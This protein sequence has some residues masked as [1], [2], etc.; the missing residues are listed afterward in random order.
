M[1]ISP[2]RLWLQSTSLLAV[3]AGYSL[4]LLFNQGMAG[5]QRRLAYERLVS[6]LVVE[7]RARAPNANQ[8][9]PLLRQALLPSLR[10]QLLSV[11]SA[12]ADSPVLQQRGA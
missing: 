9:E 1:R 5:L 2:L 12:K 7:L 8:L 6:D 4:L 10:L 3:L 11:A